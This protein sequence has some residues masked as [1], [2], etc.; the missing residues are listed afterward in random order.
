MCVPKLQ[1]SASAVIWF[2]EMTRG[3]RARTKKSVEVL[4][5]REREL[6]RYASARARCNSILALSELPGREDSQT[7]TILGLL[8]DEGRKGG[9][10]VGD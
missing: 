5:E 7:L 3:V 2:A 10:S 9:R 8:L 1:R 4:R 6:F